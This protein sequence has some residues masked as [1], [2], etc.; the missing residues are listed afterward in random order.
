MQK[1]RDV[2]NQETVTRSKVRRKRTMTVHEQRNGK[3]QEKKHHHD[4]MLVTQNRGQD[5]SQVGTE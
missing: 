2:E 1:L 5:S 4:V 3:E